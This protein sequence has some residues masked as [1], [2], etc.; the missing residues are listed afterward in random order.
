MFAEKSK[1][2]NALQNEIS[3][4]ESEISRMKED[5]RKRISVL[6]SAIQNYVHSSP[7]RF[8]ILYIFSKGFRVCWNNEMSYKFCFRHPVETSDF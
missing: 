7:K 8:R 6:Q 3:S 1:E 4:L 5:E 2:I